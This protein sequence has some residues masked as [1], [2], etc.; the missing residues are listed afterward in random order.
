MGIPNKDEQVIQHIIKYC[1]QIET[2]IEAYSVSKDEFEN[3]FVM[4]NAL[5]MP[6]LQ[7]GELV[8]KL[9]KEFRAEN[10]HIPWRA[11]AGMRDRLTHDYIEMDTEVAWEVVSEDI[12]E[13][14]RNCHVILNK[15]NIPAPKPEKINIV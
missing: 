10:P 4:Q 15:R 3:N 8:K 11:I 2:T 1:N 14:N 6:I 5:S 9:S 7:I 12:G 13:L